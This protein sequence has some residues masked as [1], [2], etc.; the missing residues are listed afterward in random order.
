[1]VVWS[2]L[3][4]SVSIL[5]QIG[6]GLRTTSSCPTMRLIWWSHYV[7]IET[8]CNTCDCLKSVFPRSHREYSPPIRDHRLVEKPPGS[9]H[10]KQ[11][12]WRGSVL[13]FSCFD[14][15][16][17]WP[18][19]YIHLYPYIYI[20]ITHYICWQY[21]QSWIRIHTYCVYLWLSV[22]RQLSSPVLLK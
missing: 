8:S 10:H 22:V 15:I 7:W 5:A 3:S 4:V 6:S 12:G 1:M 16:Y 14:A 11:C 9:E 21:L 2:C 18:H 20:H 17:V 13:E 19:T